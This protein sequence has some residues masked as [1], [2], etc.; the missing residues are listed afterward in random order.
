[1]ESYVKIFYPNLT[2]LQVKYW[3]VTLSGNYPDV[4]YWIVTVT[5]NY[6]DVKPRIVT[7]SLTILMLNVG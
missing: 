7:L 1:M 4:K 5:A 6:P 3:I 2:T